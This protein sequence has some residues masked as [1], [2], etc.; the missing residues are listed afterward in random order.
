[1]SAQF[2]T[3]PQQ[4]TRRRSDA[5][6]SESLAGITIFRGVAHD[7]LASLARRCSW[8]RY[9]AGQTI[10]LYR[11]NRHA[12]Y[13]VVQGGASVLYHS[14]SGR[15]VRF[16]DL[17]AG[18]V[19]GEFAAIDGAP[20][21]ADVVCT[22]DALVAAMSADLFREILRRHEAVCV[23]VLRRLTGIARTMSRRVIEFSTL[24]VRHRLHAELLRLARIDTAN[25]QRRTGAI[26]PAPTHAE[27][28]SR[29][30]THREAVSRELAELARHSLVE[31]RGGDLI[32]RDVHA[33]ARMVEDALEEPPDDIDLGRRADLGC[34]ATARGRPAA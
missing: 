12:V 16:G 14:A 22:T 23:A 24:P 20:H 13:F 5:T 34:V 31:R 15:E 26:T 4:A 32:L 27:I 9:G 33:L 19:F 21:M 18:D 8:R 2:L 28:A 25:P 11:E 29:I 3:L 10:V 7:D 1:M 6:L 30:S 17:Q